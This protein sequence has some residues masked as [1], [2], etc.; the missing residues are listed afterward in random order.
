MLAAPGLPFTVTTLRFCSPLSFGLKPP[1]TELADLRNIIHGVEDEMRVK[2]AQA[3]EE[4]VRKGLDD[5]LE[6][7]EKQVG[8]EMVS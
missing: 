8:G 6:Q 2:N 1:V 7:V 3:I 4:E 5:M